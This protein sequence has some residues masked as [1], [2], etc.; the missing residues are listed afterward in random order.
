MAE[1]TG[2]PS[3]DL[4]HP[5]TQALGFTQTEHRLVHQ[6]SRARRCDALRCAAIVQYARP[7]PVV[8]RCGWL[9][10]VCRVS[11]SGALHDLAVPGRRQS[12]FFWRPDRQRDFFLPPP[13]SFPPSSFSPG[14]H[15]G[16]VPPSSG[17]FVFHFQSSI[18]SF[19]SLMPEEHRALWQG[20]FLSTDTLLQA[21][22]AVYRHSD[23][24]VLSL[25]AFHPRPFPSNWSTTSLRSGHLV[26]S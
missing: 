4:P 15:F 5:Q 7:P 16:F 6:P 9:W 24:C 26:L 22:A 20:S 8:S 13:P 12:L 18:P 25:F 1:R 10:A 21:G 23:V 3:R 14:A 17:L 2:S 11:P 19:S